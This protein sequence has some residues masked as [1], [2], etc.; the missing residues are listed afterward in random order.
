MASTDD[1]RAD[2]GLARYL[3]RGD[4]ATELARYDETLDEIPKQ[5]KFFFGPRNEMRRAKVT[6]DI[7]VSDAGLDRIATQNAQ[8]MWT[9]F[10]RAWKA[11]Q[12]A[13]LC[14]MTLAWNTKGPSLR[15]KL[16]YSDETS[17]AHANP[18][19]VITAS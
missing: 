10:Q 18:S 8:A 3:L 19:T 7:L 16:A 15:F 2:L 17:R 9:R 6:T 5:R 4:A 14:N 13:Q 11:A 1:V 12:V